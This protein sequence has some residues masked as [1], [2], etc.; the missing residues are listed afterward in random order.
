MLKKHPNRTTIGSHFFFPTT[1][2]AAAISH[3]RRQFVSIGFLIH[4]GSVSESVSTTSIRYSTGS[5][6]AEQPRCQGLVSMATIQ[7][8]MPKRHAHLHS[9]PIPMPIPTPT[10]SLTSAR[11]PPVVSRDNIPFHHNSQNPL[12]H[13]SIIPIAERSGVK[14]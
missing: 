12:F 2:S 13:Y 5:S 4:S 3:S 6:W 11:G 8:V 9:I 14:F 1:R 7:L 10:S